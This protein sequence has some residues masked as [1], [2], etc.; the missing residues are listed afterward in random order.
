MA[1]GIARL[2]GIR[3]PINFDSPLRASGISD[4]YRRWH[5]TL[6][7]VIGRF[8]F[9]PLSMAAT[10]FAAGRRLPALPNRMIG[11]WLPLMLNFE[12]IALWHGAT[13]SF[14]VFG[15]IHG[16]WFVL[17]TEVKGSRL[18]RRH[19]AKTSERTR[20]IWGQVI[21]F[22]PLLLTF[23]LFRAGSLTT[24][25][26]LQASMWTNAGSFIS[27]LK[28]NGD[29]YLLIAAA[30]AIIW[31]APNSYE[32]TS[33][34]APGIL[35]WVN[36]STTPRPLANLRWRPTARWAVVVGALI[37]ASMF[38]LSRKAPFIYMGY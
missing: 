1:L 28:D 33:R 24:F 21:T 3:L 29:A 13:A 17:E 9:T 26:N 30:F 32:L 25:W 12:V 31:F 10:R 27:T 36:P 8:L 14:V 5:I 7:R 37:I 20:Q 4:Y 2:F 15:L 6:T 38:F 19:K 16:A 18:W 35:T 34:Y 22:I 11:R 23:S